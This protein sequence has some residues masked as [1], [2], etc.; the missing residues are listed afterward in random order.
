MVSW[1]L[2]SWFL[3]SEKLTIVGLTFVSF[4]WFQPPLSE[5]KELAF[6]WIAEMCLR[7]IVLVS[8]VVVGFYLYFYTFMKLG[9]KLK[10]DLRSL[11]KNG[12]Q[13][14]LGGQIRDNMFWTLASGVS[15]WTGYEVLMF[16]AMANN[17]RNA[18]L[19]CKSSMVYR[20]IFTYPYLREL[21]FLLV[22]P[23]SA[24]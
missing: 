8:L 15:I 17:C 9:K 12:K 21:L 19:V 18:P 6:G 14:T 10:Y 16:W 3:I 24:Y 23:I 4:Y 22:S 20:D 5:V 1:V 2:N 13:F 7:N 11:T